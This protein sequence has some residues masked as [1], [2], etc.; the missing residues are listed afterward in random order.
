MST[1]S[2]ISRSEILFLV[3]IFLKENKSSDNDLG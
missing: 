3:L 2:Q 1:Q